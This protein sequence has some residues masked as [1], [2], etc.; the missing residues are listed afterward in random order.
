MDYFGGIEAGGTKFKCIIA[1][2]PGH[3]LAKTTIPT[4]SPRETLPAVVSFFNKIQSENKIQ[5]RSLCLASFGP[6][7]LDPTS[8]TFGRITTTPK[9]E[10]QDFDLLPFFRSQFSIPLFMETDVNCAAIGEGTWGIAQGLSNYIYITVGTGVGGGVIVNHK[11]VTK[12]IHTETGH[13]LIQKLPDDRS[14]SVCPFHENCVEG[15]ASGPA[16]ISRWKVDPA[17]LPLEHPAWHFEAH[18]IAQMLH[19]LTVTCAP[20]RIIMGGGV[21]NNLGLLEKIRTY[22][23]ESLNRYICV[24]EILE[25]D[26]FIVPP[27]LGDLAG[28]LGAIA[29]A[30]S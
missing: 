3:I 19:N 17:T 24:N 4:Q 7:D 30:Q 10:W 8:N 26:S 11:P 21:L 2:D 1:A 5:L 9:L 29:L 15:L 13:M 23:L 22:F 6:V 14:P 25:V 20:Q 28:S 27:A 12:K 18:Y 16:L